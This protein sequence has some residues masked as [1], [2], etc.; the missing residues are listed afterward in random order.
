MAV[1]LLPRLALDPDGWGAPTGASIAAMTETIGTSLTHA[2]S[3]SLYLRLRAA[4]GERMSDGE[5]AARLEAFDM[6][7]PPPPPRPDDGGP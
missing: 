1:Q 6:R 5:L 7:R 4:A 3:T 2:V